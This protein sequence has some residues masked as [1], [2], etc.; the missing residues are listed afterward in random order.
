MVELTVTI[1]RYVVILHG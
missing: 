1:Y